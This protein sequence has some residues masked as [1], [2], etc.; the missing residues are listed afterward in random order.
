MNMLRNYKNQI[1]ELVDPAGIFLI[2]I[3]YVIYARG[4]LSRCS[5]SGFSQPRALFFGVN[6]G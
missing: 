4:I 2:G 3:F 6:Y 1:K 5:E